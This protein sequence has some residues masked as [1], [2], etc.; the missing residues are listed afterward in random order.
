MQWP[1]IIRCHK[2]ISLNGLTVRNRIFFDVSNRTP[3]LVR[4]IKEDFPTAAN[5]GWMVWITETVRAKPQAAVVLKVRDHLFSGMLVFA[6][7]Q[8]NVIAHDRARVAGVLE[9]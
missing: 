8:V 9:Q 4:M 5:P 2:G 3:D 6:D 7:D 1:P